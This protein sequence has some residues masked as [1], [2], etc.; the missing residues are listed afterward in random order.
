MVFHPLGGRNNK[1][2]DWLDMKNKRADWIKDDVHTS[3]LHNLVSY[4][5]FARDV[6]KKK[7]GAGL[8]DNLV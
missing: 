6:G 2:N 5:N 8:E 1:I 4:G 7:N 3:F